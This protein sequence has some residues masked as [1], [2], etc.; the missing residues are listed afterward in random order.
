MEF[1]SLAAQLAAMYYAG[2]KGLRAIFSSDE[3]TGLPVDAYMPEISLA[4]TTFKEGTKAFAI[5]RY[6]CS[7]K[8]IRMVNIPISK[9][10]GRHIVQAVKEA[11]GSC[12]V[13][14]ISDTDRDTDFIRERFF[15]W[16]YEKMKQM[17]DKKRL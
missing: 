16:K 15:S 11:F 10:A 1:N 8:G 4:I 6:I 12:H 7:E 2:R 5:S 14:I 13:Y 9:K 17:Q 3:L